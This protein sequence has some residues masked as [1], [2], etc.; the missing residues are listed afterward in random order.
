M[1]DLMKQYGTY[2]AFIL[3][4][5]LMMA[6]AVDWVRIG[7]ADTIDIFIGP[8]SD[9]FGLPFFAV[10]L[11]LSGLTG[12][13]SSLIQKYTIDYEKMQEVQ[14]K[15][16]D[17]QMKYREAQLSGD[18]KAIKKLEVKRDAMMKDQLEM[19]K[20]QFTPMA[21]IILV[22]VP[23]FFWFLHRFHTMDVD[24]LLTTDTAIVFPFAGVIGLHE[25]AIWIIPAWILWYMI[26]SLT[27]S[28]V[29]RKALNIGGI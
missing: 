1:L 7:I 17:F 12:L 8:L 24:C 19:S 26:C 16:K 29:I 5:G 4:F 13:Y 6:Y 23:I 3:A 20:Q 14:A 10:I 21:Y 2:I 15:M 9:T 28:Q 22:T 18:E 11:F 27:V 25:M